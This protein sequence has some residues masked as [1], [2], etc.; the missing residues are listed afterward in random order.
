VI[1]YTDQAGNGTQVF[2]GNLAL[3][4]TVNSTI[5]VTD[6]GVFN[7]TG[8]GI[9]SGN[10]KVAIFDFTNNVLVTPIVTF[11]GVYTVAGAGF[12]V[13]Q[14]ISPVVLGPGNYQVDAVGFNV[15]DPNG[16]INLGGS[17]PVL[18][19]GGGLLTFTGAAFD[20]SVSLDRPTTCV[21]CQGPPNDEHQFSAG[22]FVFQAG[23]LTPE[24]GS[25]LLFGAGIGGL[26]F[27]LRR[28]TR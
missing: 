23:I 17:G 10:L 2:S 15:N 16:N 20:G 14:A 26:I 11:H 24:P 8:S 22:T 4:F 7:A 21:G 9:I 1:P 5:T 18:N 27:R 28:R 6:L 13:F 3:N 12:D 25:A 19:T